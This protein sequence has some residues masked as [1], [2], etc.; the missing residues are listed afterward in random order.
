MITSERTPIKGYRLGLR[1]QAKISLIRKTGHFKDNTA[2]VVEAINHLLKEY[3][4]GEE[5][6]IR[7]SKLLDQEEKTKREGRKKEYFVG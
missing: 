3:N 2:V 4:I 6:I 1:V 5:D 7:E